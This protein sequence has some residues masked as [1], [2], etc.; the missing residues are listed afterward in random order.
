[1]FTKAAKSGFPIAQTELG[2]MLYAGKFIDKDLVE[3][4][5]WLELASKVNYQRAKI[6]LLQ[7]TFMNNPSDSKVIKTLLE[8]NVKIN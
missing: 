8:S 5:K 4:K 3:S 2:E 6:D 7:L 1:M